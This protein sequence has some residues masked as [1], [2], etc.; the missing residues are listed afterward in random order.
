MS[1]YVRV[2]QY[3]KSRTG[4]I[5]WR[6]GP[7]AVGCSSGHRGMRNTQIDENAVAAAQPESFCKKCF[8]KGKPQ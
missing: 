1:N 8:P 7:Q 4:V 6:L 2:R 5:H 3:G